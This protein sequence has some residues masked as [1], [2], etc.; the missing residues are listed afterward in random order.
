MQNKLF[1]LICFGLLS[2]TSDYIFAQQRADPNFDPTIENPTYSKA[3]GPK[4][5][6]DSA[7]NNF[8]TADGRYRPFAELLKKDGYQVISS[9]EPFNDKSLKEAD[10]LVVS[11]ALHKSNLRSWALP[12]PSAFTKN[13]ISV[14]NKWVKQGGGLLLIADHMPFAGASEE[15]AASFGFRFK[16]GFA[17]NSEQG[18]IIRFR[19]GDGSLKDHAITRGLDK[20][21]KI[22]S[23]FT[24][25]GQAFEGPPEA[26]PLLVFGESSYL[27]VPQKAWQFDEKT[28]KISID[29]WFQGAVRKYGKGRVAVFG[30]AAAF[31]AQIAGAARSKIGMNSPV[32]EENYQ[33]VLNVMHWLSELMKYDNESKTLK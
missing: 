29:G 31:T 17:F 1:L 9:S 14:L 32:A 5:L 18:G 25:T 7:H 19:R 21:Q 15:L 3:K 24:F 11:N 16:N 6:I 12:T 4:V 28:K 10:I 26:E 2:I 22:D 20:E 23:I 33:F 13:E 8:H 30:E 27:L